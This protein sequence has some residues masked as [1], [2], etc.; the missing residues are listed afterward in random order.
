VSRRATKYI[1]LLGWP[2]STPPT[3]ADI[4]GQIVHNDLTMMSTAPA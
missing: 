2:S 1:Q 4:I 3:P